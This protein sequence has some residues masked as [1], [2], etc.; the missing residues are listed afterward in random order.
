MIKKSLQY[1]LLL[2]PEYVLVKLILFS[3]ETHKD[4]IYTSDDRERAFVELEVK[5]ERKF[6]GHE[7]LKQLTR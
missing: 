2:R 7:A 6:K 3:R 4:T 1:I 5:K